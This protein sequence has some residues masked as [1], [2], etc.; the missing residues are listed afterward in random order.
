MIRDGER[1]PGTQAA[2]NR[3]SQGQIQGD[4]LITRPSERFAKYQQIQWPMACDPDHAC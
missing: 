1:N 2:S 4:A 3:F